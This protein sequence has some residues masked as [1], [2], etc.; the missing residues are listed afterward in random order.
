MMLNKSTN[1]F[2]ITCMSALKVLFFFLTG[3][4]GG[5][6]EIGRSIMLC[7]WALFFSFF[8][9]LFLSFFFLLVFVFPIITN[10]WYNLVFKCVIWL[11]VFIFHSFLCFA[12]TCDPRNIHLL[13]KEPHLLCNTLT[14]A[15]SPGRCIRLCDT[16][17]QCL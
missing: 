10:M 3:G 15:L 13:I 5:G 1:D 4:G 12:T 14:S 7:I 2:Q 16:S 11:S 8:F 6:G 9:F 17:L